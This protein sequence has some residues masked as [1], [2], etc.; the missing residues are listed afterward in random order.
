MSTHQIC[1]SC[2]RISPIS[3]EITHRNDCKNSQIKHYITDEDAQIYELYPAVIFTNKISEPTIIPSSDIKNPFTP[4]NDTECRFYNEN[5]EI[6]VNID[7]NREN[8]IKI[9]SSFSCENNIINQS[10]KINNFNEKK[11]EL[12]EN[13]FVYEDKQDYEITKDHDGDKIH[14]CKIC[15][16]SSGTLLLIPHHINCRYSDNYLKIYDSLDK[17]F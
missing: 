9:S 1:D 4:V 12:N 11:L 6:I 2:K 14:I 3:T 15:S 17:L 16:V 7:K 8:Q 10:L 5:T 13:S